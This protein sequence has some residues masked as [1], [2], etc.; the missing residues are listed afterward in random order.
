MVE[1]LISIIIPCYNRASLIGETL[2]SI[3][4]QSYKNWECIVVDDGSSDYTL[5]LVSLYCE[6]DSRIKY[7]KRPNN[8]K[9]GANTCRNYGFEQSK[10]EYIQWFDSD[11][12][13]VPNFL[14]SKISVLE[15]SNADYVISKTQN[16]QDPN[17]DHVINENENYYQFDKF[18]VNGFNYVS[19]RI[20]WLTP[21]LMIRRKLAIK[22]IFNTKMNSSQEYNFFSKLT[23]INNNAVVID[24]F[25][26]LRRV[27]D[28]SIRARFNNDPDKEKEVLYNMLET[29][30]EVSNLL[31]GSHVEKFF[32]DRLLKLNTSE[33][34]DIVSVTAVYKELKTQGR[35][36]AAIYMRLYLY[37]NKLIG[38]GNFLRRKFIDSL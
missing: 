32:L 35:S 20:N 17:V 22:I 31:P 33:N 1:K 26:T 23:C 18:E 15:K 3:I 4:I 34:P 38:K 7:L 28:D 5:E 6:K 14:L 37:L 16:F 36:K 2:D 8:R 12:L 13:M 30:K 19:Q 10:G 27:H 21:D 29:W 24:E 9:K 11:D 25:L